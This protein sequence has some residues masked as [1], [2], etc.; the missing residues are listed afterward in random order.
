MP[1]IFIFLQGD[2][3]IKYCKNQLRVQF[4][5]FCYLYPYFMPLIVRHPKG[6]KFIYQ[7]NDII[8]S[9]KLSRQLKLNEKINI[10][11]AFIVSGL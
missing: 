11:Q 10:N 3:V 6:P 8:K 4:K 1:R 7:L 2:T 5:L 9:L